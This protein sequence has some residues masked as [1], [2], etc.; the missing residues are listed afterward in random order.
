[1]IKT[2]VFFILFFLIFFTT[3]LCNFLSILHASFLVR[4]TEQGLPK[5]NKRL[6]FLCFIIEKFLE[7]NFFYFFLYLLYLKIFVLLC[8]ILKY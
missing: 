7:G 3:R 2:H 8:L 1:M 5:E 4:P 6:T